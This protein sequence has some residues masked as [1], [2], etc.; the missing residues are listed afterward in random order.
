MKAWPVPVDGESNGWRR[1]AQRQ[2]EGC[3]FLSIG[4]ILVVYRLELLHCI[5]IFILSE[6]LHRHTPATRNQFVHKQNQDFSVISFE[7]LVFV[8]HRLLIIGKDTVWAL[9]C[10][11]VV[12]FSYSFIWQHYLNLCNIVHQL[13]WIVF[14]SLRNE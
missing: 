6:R 7:C 9:P 1:L 8:T 11:T 4:Y 13:M 14:L 3:V 12:F 10:L 2:N 5:E